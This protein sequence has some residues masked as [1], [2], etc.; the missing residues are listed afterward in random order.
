MK[1][2]ITDM[3]ELLALLRGAKSVSKNSSGVFIDLNGGKQINIWASYEDGSV[4]VDL[5]EGLDE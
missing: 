4:Y 1:R 3:T 2:E 5:I